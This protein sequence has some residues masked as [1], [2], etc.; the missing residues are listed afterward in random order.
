MVGTAQ[1][2]TERKQTE[3]AL[4]ESRS[5]LEEAQS[6]A[7]LGHWSAELATGELKW[8]DEI[9]RIFGQDP[10]HFTPTIDAFDLAVHPDDLELVN[11]SERRASVTGVHD[12]VHRIVRPDGE[13]RYVHELAHAQT[14]AAGQVVRLTGTVQDVTELKQ[15]EHAMLQ[16]KEAAEAASRAKSEFSRA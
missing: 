7:K 11:E 10:A 3:M 12:V 5:R 13:V 16:A 8:S 1:D 9:Y 14:D 15:T 2:I 6:L 4:Q